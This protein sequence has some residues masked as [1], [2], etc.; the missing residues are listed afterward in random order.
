VLLKAKQQ[1]KVDLPRMGEAAQ[2]ILSVSIDERFPRERA[3]DAIVSAIKV[4]GHH[5]SA[6][7]LLYQIVDMLANISASATTGLCVQVHFIMVYSIA[8]GLSP[9]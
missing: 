8:H 7:A 6:V 3:V 4:I 5:R 2:I 9:V 1:V